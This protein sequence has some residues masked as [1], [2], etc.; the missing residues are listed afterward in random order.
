MTSAESVMNANGHDVN[1][2]PKIH[3][4]HQI[5]AGFAYR[6]GGV[7]AMTICNGELPLIVVDAFSVGS[8][9]K[10]NVNM[11]VKVFEETSGANRQL[12]R[13]T[14]TGSTKTA[15]PSIFEVT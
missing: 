2:V 7:A 15:S 11:A 10:V 9:A 8:P 14:L 1:W 5:Q 12:R 4:H 3:T 13:A 6:S